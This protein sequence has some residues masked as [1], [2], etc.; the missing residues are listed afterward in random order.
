[1]KNGRAIDPTLELIAKRCL[2]VDTLTTRK[3]DALDFRE[4]AIWQIRD[5][6]EAAYA[7]GV[8]AAGGRPVTRTRKDSKAR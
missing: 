5:A 3:S 1:M 7:T 4:Y 2:G 8:A 6:L